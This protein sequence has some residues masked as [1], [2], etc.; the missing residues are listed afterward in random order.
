MERRFKAALVALLVTLGMLVVAPVVLNDGIL[1]ALCAT[2][3]RDSVPW[4]LL[5]CTNHNDSTGG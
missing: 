2:L 4:V 3:E 5:G 1:D